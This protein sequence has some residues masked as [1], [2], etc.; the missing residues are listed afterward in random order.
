MS[1]QVSKA[2]GAPAYNLNFHKNNMYIVLKFFLQARGLRWSMDI[3][4]VFLVQIF[5]KFY[6]KKSKSTDVKIKSQ[7]AKSAVSPTGNPG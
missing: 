3:I 7:Y 4:I 2:T 6:V 5:L 1:H